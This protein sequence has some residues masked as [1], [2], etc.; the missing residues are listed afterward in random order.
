MSDV[1][2]VADRVGLIDQGKLSQ[3]LTM[4]EL[5]HQNSGNITLTF[6]DVP[7]TS[8]FDAVDGVSN[9]SASGH[10]LSFHVDGAVTAALARAAE[11]GAV[12]IRTKE[13][14]LEDIFLSTYADEAGR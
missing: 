7:D 4:D 10:D 2:R 12:G 3:E 8:W 1:D 14:D 5:R 11:L 9:V 6:V 13:H